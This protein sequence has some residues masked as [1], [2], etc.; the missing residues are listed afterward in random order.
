MRDHC[1]CKHEHACIH[2][3]IRGGPFATE[4]CNDAWSGY[5]LKGIALQTLDYLYTHPC[6]QLAMI[7][8]SLGLSNDTTRCALNRLLEKGL[9][10]KHVAKDPELSSYEA[11]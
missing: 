1:P 10:C 6:E 9:V 11:L 3:V 2:S 4:R 7:A 8:Q 5:K